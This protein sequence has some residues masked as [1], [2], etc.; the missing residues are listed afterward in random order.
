MHAMITNVQANSTQMNMHQS[1]S[2]AA[3]TNHKVLTV[4][5]PSM[6]ITQQ[7]GLPPS[8]QS[9]TI[10]AH[11]AYIYAFTKDTQYLRDITNINGYV[12][13]IKAKLHAI[14]LI[15]YTK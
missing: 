8:S 13:S 10:N 6:V 5:W 3:I 12:W 7:A 14:T 9:T 15:I 4:H 11:T 1:R 2:G